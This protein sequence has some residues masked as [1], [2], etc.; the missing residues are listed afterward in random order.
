MN[1]WI[2]RIA[3]FERKISIVNYGISAL[4]FQFVNSLAL[5]LSYLLDKMGIRL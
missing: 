1:V 2:K 5:Y 3:P 4:N